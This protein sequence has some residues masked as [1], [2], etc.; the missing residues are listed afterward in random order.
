MAAK[1]AVYYKNIR[2]FPETGKNIFWGMVKLWTFFGGHHNWA[3]FF[4]GGGEG[5]I[6]IIYILF[7]AFS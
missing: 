1:I 6:Y 2:I 3:F 4:L 7:R 5:V